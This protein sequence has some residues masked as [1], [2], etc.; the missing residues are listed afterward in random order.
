MRPAGSGGLPAP[1]SQPLL[2]GRK[3]VA[4]A[5]QPRGHEHRFGVHGEMDQRAALELEDRL[6]RVAVLLVLPARIFH[7]L[8]GERVLQL[9]RG[10][11]DAVQAEGDIERFL[12]ARREVQL[13]GQPQAVRGVARLQL[14]VQLVRRLE[15]GRVQR[16]PVAL[17][18]VA[19]RRQRAVG[20]HPLAQVAEDLLA[21]LR[22]RAAPPAWPTPSAGCRG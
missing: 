17:E 13:P 16:P 6:A 20:V 1:P 2:K 21:G 8:A 5:C 15:E 10:D 7:R 12:R 11:G 4:D 14:R 19:Q 3:C 9:Q 18:A 22:R